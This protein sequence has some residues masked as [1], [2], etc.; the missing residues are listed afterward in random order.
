MLSTDIYETKAT[1]GTAAITYTAGD[2]LYASQN[3]LLT[4]SSGMA[5]SPQYAWHTRVGTLL[6][7]P[8]ATDLFMTVQMKI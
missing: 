7:V 1:D 4:N 3:G 2:L 5:I 6:K 8:T